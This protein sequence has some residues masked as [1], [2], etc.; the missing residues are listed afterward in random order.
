MK[1]L[2][3]IHLLISWKPLLSL[4]LN[5]SVPLARLADKQGDETKESHMNHGA[6]SLSKPVKASVLVVCQAQEEIVNVSK[7]NLGS[8]MASLPLKQFELSKV[9]WKYP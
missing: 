7:E 3:L 9:S 2:P 8:L 5:Y 1:N 4:H 6:E